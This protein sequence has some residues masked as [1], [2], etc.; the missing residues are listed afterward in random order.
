MTKPKKGNAVDQHI[1]ARVRLRRLE[2]EL[3]Q[4]QLAKQLGL[5]FQQVQKYEKGTNRIGGS[6]MH[7][8]ALILRVPIAYF[9]QGLES[10]NGATSELSELS[11]GA[12]KVAQQFDRLP[13]EIKTAVSNLVR[14]CL[15]RREVPL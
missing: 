14:S 2:L 7:Q 13:Q 3:S 1:G 11:A 6:R 5:T 15:E 12:I 9:Y 4:D 10:G 8:I